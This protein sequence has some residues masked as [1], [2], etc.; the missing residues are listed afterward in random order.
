LLEDA[1]TDGEL[2]NWEFLLLS[3]HMLDHICALI[4]WTSACVTF[5]YLISIR[6]LWLMLPMAV[7]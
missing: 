5:M 7:F 2:C 3:S 4:S 1:T 6:N